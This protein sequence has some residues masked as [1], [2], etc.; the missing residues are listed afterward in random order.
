[1]IY[2]LKRYDPPRH[3]EFD[4]F[5][6]CAESPREARKL[7]SYEAADEGGRTWLSP[8]LSSCHA[9][10]DRIIPGVVLGSFNAG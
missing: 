1:M 6:V 2:Y 3:D 4:G 8:D 10:R 7:A 9:I 5:V